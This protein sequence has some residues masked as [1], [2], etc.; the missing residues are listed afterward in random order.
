MVKLA[1]CP[2][3]GG[4]ASIDE[5]GNFLGDPAWAPGCDGEDCLASILWGKFATQ[6]EAI[7]AWNRRAP[8]EELLSALTEAR[9]ALHQHYVDWDG[10]PEDAV[11]LQ[12]AR[13]KCDAAIALY[14]EQ[15]P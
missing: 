11:P 3:C 15:T 10:E 5:V 13:A 12:L 2:F 9:A 6:A 7:T 1:P 14:R 8:V 4:E